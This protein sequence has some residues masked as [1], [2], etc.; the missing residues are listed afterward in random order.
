MADIIQLL[1][2]SVANQ[3][4]AGEVIQRPASVIKELVENAVDAGADSIKIIVK[5]AGKTLIQV[6]DNGVGMSETDAR[7]AFERHA[8]SKIK[9]ANDLFAI[10]T[11]GFR[12]E[13]LASIA[14]IAHVT[15]KTRQPDNEIGTQLVLSGSEV[16]SQEPVSCPIGSNFMIK[17]LFFNV[18]ARRKFLKSNTT[19]FKHILTELQRIALTHPDVEF[20]LVHNDQ[21]ISQFP[22]TNL[23]QRIIHVMG[24]HMNQN[25][26]SLETNT[27][28]INISGFIGKPENARKTSGEQYFFIN[29]RYMRH[30]Y[31]HRAIMKAFENI[32]PG[33]YYPSYFIYF[34]A[35][36]QTIDVN[37][38]P[39]KTEI[40]F[41]SEQAIFQIIN[42]AVK[43]AL[44]KS[45]TVP[46]IDFD[47][48]G[49]VDIPV[50]TKDTQINA[51]T[52][53]I[54]H[55]FNPFETG[56]K[57]PSPAGTSG[58][59]SKGFEKTQPV[60]EDWEKLYSGPNI[61]VLNSS[62]ETNQQLSFNS[63]NTGNEETTKPSSDYLQ[64]KGKYILTSVKSGLM[65]IDQRRA[66]V[67]ILF[68]K[69]VRNMAMN[70]SASQRSLYP[71]SL[72]LSNED[73]LMVREILEDL[74]SIGFDISDLGSNTIVVNG[75]PDTSEKIAPQRLV[76]QMIEEYKQT[77]SSVHGNLKERLAVS[78]ARASAINYGKLL[79]SQEMQHLVDELFACENP[80]YTPTGKKTLSLV[81]LGELEKYFN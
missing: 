73:Y 8:T 81:S 15:L 71:D 77:E 59:R 30:P 68:E 65:V 79:S 2:D 44:G 61:Q 72:D 47:T 42:A 26:N 49:V 11:K 27:T 5:D 57:K 20:T 54:D 16:E 31:F 45:N 78:L 76:E 28:L 7:L 17:N 74:N 24:K 70:K 69:Y 18:P 66:H 12:G 25:L 55:N 6:S 63:E 10:R 34:E 41:E 21:V 62:M 37:I 22:Q 35:D 39:T 75:V 9:S 46:S 23:R 67:R 38:H 3:I 51:P 32:L 60:P 13:A 64:L 50:M 14:S 36:P 52:I 43:E 1:P 19:E 40:K 48:H 58:G 53:E 4:A 33:D 80:N 29:Q 56:S